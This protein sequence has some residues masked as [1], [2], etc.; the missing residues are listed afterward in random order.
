M[1]GFLRQRLFV[2]CDS[3][4]RSYVLWQARPTT[5]SDSLHSNGTNSMLYNADAVAVVSL[6]D[7]IQ[8]HSW[9]PSLAWFWTASS[10]K[11]INQSKNLHKVHDIKPAFSGPLE[12]WGPMQEHRLR[13]PDIDHVQLHDVNAWRQKITIMK[14]LF[15]PVFL[16]F[17]KQHWFL[18]DSQALPVCSSGKSN[19]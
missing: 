13:Q 10:D 1:Q 9:K 4:K 12:E 19:R 8:K 2:S 11:S 15:Y 6:L 7:P 5:G 3:W 17:R 16:D 18:E 14:V